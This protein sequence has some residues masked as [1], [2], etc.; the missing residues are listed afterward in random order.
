M[1]YKNKTFRISEKALKLCDYIDFKYKRNERYIFDK[2]FKFSLDY[3]SKN[4]FN[5]KPKIYDGMRIVKGF[6]LSENTLNYFNKSLNLIRM[7]N[8]DILVSEY[9]EII[10]YLYAMKH[11]SDE[12]LNMFH[13]KI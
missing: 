1:E 5:Y 12:E 9:V 2:I 13:I 8:V 6:T 4:G 7:R 10:L 3:I 11:F